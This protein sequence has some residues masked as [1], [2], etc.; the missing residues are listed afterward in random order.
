[1]LSECYIYMQ[2]YDNDPDMKSVKEIFDRKTSQRFEEYE[3][4][5]ITQR[6]KYKEQRDKDIQEIIVKDKINKSLPEKLEKC[7]LKSGC[8]LGAVAASVGIFR[9]LALNEM[10]KPSLLV[11]QKGI[12]VVIAKAIKVLGKIVEVSYFKLINWAPMVTPTIYNQRMELVQIVNPINS[13]ST[14]SAAAGKTLFCKGTEAWEAANA[15]V[16]AGEASK[17]A[18]DAEIYLVNTE[19]RKLYSAIGYSVIAIL[20]ILLIMKKKDE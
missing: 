1:M 15:A 11:V 4:R 7:C 6:Q 8:G 9:A 10:K 12:D 13:K 14:E 19:N 17:T 2:N 16:A 18:E 5:M 3:E 20:I